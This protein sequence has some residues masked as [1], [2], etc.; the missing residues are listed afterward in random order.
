[1]S[2]ILETAWYRFWTTFGRKW[3]SYLTVLVL[4]G[5]LGGL[6]MGSIAGAR[7]TLAS[8]SVYVASRNPFALDSGTGRNAVPVRSA[9]LGTVL[10]LWVVVTTVTFGTSL[11][12]W[13]TVDGRA[14]ERRACRWWLQGLAPPSKRCSCPGGRGRDMR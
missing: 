2:R 10:A 9:I 5:L 3:G 12:R 6:A 8:P 11:N 4:I 14:R 7:R 1:M 13:S